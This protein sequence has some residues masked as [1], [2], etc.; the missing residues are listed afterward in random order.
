MRITKK[1]LLHLFGVV[2]LLSLIPL[3]EKYGLAA[4]VIVCFL[5]LTAFIAAGLMK[6]PAKLDGRNKEPYVCPYKV[7][8]D[9]K[10]IRVFLNDKL[11]ESVS[12]DRLTAVGVRID[13][14]FLPA[15]WWMLFTSPQSG[16]MYPSEAK[17]GQEMLHEMQQR[18]S[19]F[20]NRAVIEAM[21][22]MEGGRLVWS[23][24][25]S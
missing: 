25:S 2:L 6:S 16:C 24:E 17:G 20:D 22:L 3:S 15:P 1:S 18:L 4:T 14:S 19:G 9:D 21:G 11:H 8:F 12:W 5:A 7:E 13:E 10:D 23:R